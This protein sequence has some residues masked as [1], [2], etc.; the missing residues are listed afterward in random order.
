MIEPRIYRAAFVP[1]LL[2]VVLVMFSLES[3]PR[4]LPQGLAADVV[5][6]GDQAAT[7]ARAVLAAGRDRRAGTPGDL[8][9]AELVEGQLEARGFTVRSDRFDSDGNELVNVVGRRPG[10]S[11]RQVLVVAARDA[12]GVPDAAGSAADTAALV[13]IARVFEGRPSQKTLVLA[14]VDGSALGEL[15]TARLAADL[16]DPGLVDGAIVISGFGLENRKPATI[17]AWAG[18][19][20][21]AGIGLTRTVA[22][23]LR[24]EQG[25]APESSSPAGQIARM[26]FPVGVGPQGVLLQEGYDTV[27]IAGEGE[28]PGGG[29]SAIESLDEER[30]ERLGRATL[31]TLTALDAGARPTRGP[32]SYVTAVSQVIPGWA[33]RVLAFALILPA[34]VA[35]VDAFA[36]ARRRRE[37]LGA[38]FTWFAASVLPFVIGLGVAHGLALVGATEAPPDFPV[39][40]DLYPLDAG[41][42][43]VLA[44]VV[45]VVA[46]SWFAL[47]RLVRASDP[48][49]REPSAP[50]AGVVVALALSFSVL[51]L[52]A[53]NAYCALVLVPALHLWLL[54]VLFDPP[55]PRRARIVMVLGGLLAPGLLVAYDLLTLSLDPLSG[56]W[57][58]FLLVTG[59]HVSV[60]SALV[61]CV[62]AAVLCSVVAI[63]KARPQTPPPGLRPVT[64]SVRGPASYA[65]PGSLGGTSSALPRR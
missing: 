34:L 16:G 28:L 24:E 21:R 54:G 27:R 43:I 9:A 19:T 65:G 35:S 44:G 31:R 60:A 49:L 7:T 46:L 63:A 64:P 40:P 11:R 52:W 37:P 2:A 59:G 45:L 51:A 26:A 50:G 53:V 4:P 17:E 10:K 48:R 57:Y 22:E 13:E 62:L 33:M 6:D 39:A 36:R 32:D 23:S 14:S 55:P 58:S 30:L 29:D 8:A 12:R 5:F 18:N 25:V 1:A 15:G 41:A 38:W 42:A 3:R 61:A 20:N 56:A 47:R